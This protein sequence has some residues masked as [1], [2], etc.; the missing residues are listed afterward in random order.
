M[1]LTVLGSGT[2]VPRLDR[3]TPGY[4]LEVDGKNIL[5]DCSVMALQQMLKAGIDYQDI[6]I[7]A[8]NHF[9]PDHVA[10]LPALLQGLNWTPEF[11]RK[12]PLTILRV[13]SKAQENI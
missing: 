6:D 7:I 1:K 2:C 11:D 5:I 12:K 10:G 13:N 4:F 3:A 9:H 8:I